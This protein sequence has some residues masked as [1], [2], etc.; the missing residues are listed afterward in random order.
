MRQLFLRH[1]ENILNGKIIFH[2]K[3]INYY[4]S[5]IYTNVMGQKISL[6]RYQTCHILQLLDK[7]RIIYTSYMDAKIRHRTYSLDLYDNLCIIL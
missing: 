4:V 6:Y 7:V 2:I 5:D 1:V 3:K